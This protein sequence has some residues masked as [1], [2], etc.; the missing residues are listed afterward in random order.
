MNSPCYKFLLFLV[1]II[2]INGCKPDPDVY[3]T[4]LIPKPGY[5]PPDTS[6]GTGPGTGL[7]TGTGTNNGDGLPLGPVGSIKVQI[8]GVIFNYNTGAS[9]ATYYPNSPE[10]ILSPL[11]GQTSIIGIGTNGPYDIFTLT[12]LNSKTGVFD[13]EDI[14]ASDL[15][16]DPAHAGKV[17]ITAL[18]YANY[19]GTL[20]GTFSADL[21]D[22]K[23]KVHPHVIGSF[24]LKM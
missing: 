4:K 19:R 24:N 22:D 7:G 18:S 3:P 6:K 10:A 16:D 15:S 23:G 12:F 2:T 8:D 17:K 20:Q 1:L 21:V 14:I 9:F 11:N 5:T 13:I